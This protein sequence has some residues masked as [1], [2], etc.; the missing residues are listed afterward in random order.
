[1]P[2]AGPVTAPRRCT[3][4]E[5]GHDLARKHDMPPGLMPVGKFTWIR[6]R[7]VLGPATFPPQKSAALLIVAAEL[8]AEA[9]QDGSG[10]RPGAEAIGEWTGLSRVT[11]NRAVARLAELG[12][13]YKAFDARG[14]GRGRAS[15]GRAAVWELT[16][17]A[18][19][20]L[21]MEKAGYVLE[22]RGEEDG[23]ARKYRHAK[24]MRRPG[25]PCLPASRQARSGKD[26]APR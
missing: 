9:G 13:I 5:S 4:C 11:I 8:Q 22:W 3:R 1:M 25:E 26:G 10:I 24:K 2:G 17:R 21:L 14:A 6:V 19:H 23:S 12:L 16:M 15:G 7:R 20:E 18:E